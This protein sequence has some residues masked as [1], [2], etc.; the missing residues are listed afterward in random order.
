MSQSNINS[1]LFQWSGHESL[2]SISIAELEALVHENTYSPSLQLLLSKKYALEGAE[3]YTDQIQ[4]AVSYFPSALHL[5]QWLGN[6]ATDDVIAPNEE[7]LNRP[8]DA[9]GAD[10]RC[11]SRKARTWLRKAS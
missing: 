9:R 7:K 11:S 1:I 5:H 2:E 3:Q 10:W 6:E 4:K 8:T